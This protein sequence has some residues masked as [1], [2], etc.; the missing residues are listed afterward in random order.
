MHFWR[1]FGVQA[2]FC[3]EYYV[4]YEYWIHFTYKIGVPLGV[5]YG[6]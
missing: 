4:E 5:K 6:V 3:A 2:I 1:S